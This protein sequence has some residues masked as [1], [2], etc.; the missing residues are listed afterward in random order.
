MSWYNRT[1]IATGVALVVAAALSVATTA[2]ASS[3]TAAH[4]SSA[5]LDHIYVIMLEN[6]SQSSVI[7]DP[8]A[9]F[10]T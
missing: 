3:D 7:D 2:S 8:N 4:H 9:P 10:I 6:H 5:A 1:T